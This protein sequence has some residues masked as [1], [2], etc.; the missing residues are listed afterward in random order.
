MTCLPEESELA[1][2]LNLRVSFFICCLILVLAFFDLD[3]PEDDFGSVSLEPSPKCRNAASD[4]RAL[5]I[6]SLY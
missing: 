5:C 6:I 3:L 4:V 2:D 1:S